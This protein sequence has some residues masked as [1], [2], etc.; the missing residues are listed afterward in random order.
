M[1]FV[2]KMYFLQAPNFSLITA[3][4]VPY[5]GQFNNI[6]YFWMVRFIKWRC[7]NDDKLT[8][9]LKMS[10]RNYINVIFGLLKRGQDP[11]VTRIFN[12]HKQD[13]EWF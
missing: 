6:H 8:F 1:L 3:I 7:T 9:L 11:S 5:S 13:G 4:F 12:E 10:C 2:F